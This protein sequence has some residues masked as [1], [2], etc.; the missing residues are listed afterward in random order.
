MCLPPSSLVSTY[1]W[2]LAFVPGF[3]VPGLQTTAPLA[4]SSLS[5]PLTR[6]PTASPAIPDSN[7]LW[8]ISTPVI[9]VFWLWP[10]PTISTSSPTFTSPLS[11]RPVTTVPLPL[12]LNTSSTGIKKGRSVGLSGIGTYSSTWFINSI[13][14]SDHSPFPSSSNAFN[15]L[16]LIIGVSSPGKPYSVN[17]SLTSISTNSR[18][19]SSSITS[20]LLSAT[21]I[22]G[23]LT[24]LASNKC[25]L[26]CGIGPSGALTTSMA[27]SIWAAPVIIFLM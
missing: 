3:K 18:S 16:T 25:S 2:A 13:T 4:I 6:Q 1:I 14:F 9:V 17:N 10:K 27:P 26:V 20:V 5:S 24:C 11:T 22:L 8:N 23:T 7:D 12:I 21:T 19:S 15:A